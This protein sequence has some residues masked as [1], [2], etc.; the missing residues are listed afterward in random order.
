[1]KRT[2]TLLAALSLVVA[3]AAFAQPGDVLDYTPVECMPGGQSAML[4]L[5]VTQKGELRAY[6][7]HVNSTE[8]CSVVGNNAGRLS[9]V[10]MPKFQVGDE[11]EY[12]FVLLDG[13]RVIAKSPE[14]YRV[15]NTSGCDAYIA[16]HSTTFSIDCGQSI[17]G[18]PAS[19][20]AAHALGYGTPPTN[21]S[22][23]R[24]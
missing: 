20:A 10:V 15:K 23:E 22:P 21:P 1:M 19:N 6:F 7:R 17:A 2:A 24:P 16:R 11:I 5:N 18:M 14:I 4:Q 12:F 13:K 3:G 9:T 8:W